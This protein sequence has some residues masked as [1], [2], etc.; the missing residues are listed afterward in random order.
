MK[1]WLILHVGPDGNEWLREFK[2]RYTT[3]VDVETF[4]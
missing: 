2:L 1:K 3:E 4:P